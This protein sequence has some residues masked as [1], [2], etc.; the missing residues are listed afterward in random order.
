MAEVGTKPLFAIW[1]RQ[2]NDAK[3]IGLNALDEVW[4]AGRTHKKKIAL[5]FGD[6]MY[7]ASFH[8]KLYGSTD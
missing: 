5:F 1:K 3:L 6:N 4:I 8:L 2:N 7:T